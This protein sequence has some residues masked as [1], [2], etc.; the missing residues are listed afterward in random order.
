MKMIRETLDYLKSISTG[1]DAGKEYLNNF[2]VMDQMTI[3]LNAKILIA[4]SAA[5]NEPS[6]SG[7]C[8]DC[9]YRGT[10]PGDCHSS[11]HNALAVAIGEEHGIKHGW[12]LHPFNFDPIWLRYC[13][14]FEKKLE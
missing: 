10:I 6:M 7:A 5:E 14:G 9:R 1:K 12:F 4:R 8:Y 13:D 11:C 2:E 3:L